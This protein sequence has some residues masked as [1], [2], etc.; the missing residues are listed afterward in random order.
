MLKKINN[1]GK[2]LFSKISQRAVEVRYKANC[3][4]LSERGSETVDKLVWVAI[5][6]AG[7]VLIHGLYTGW[8]PQLWNKMTGKIDLIN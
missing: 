2:K 1:V 8:I 6:V 5:V 7:A 4:V 3:L